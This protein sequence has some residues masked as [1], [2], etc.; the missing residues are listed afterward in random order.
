MLTSRNTKDA[1]TQG[2]WSRQF[3]KYSSRNETSNNI[4]ITFL[5]FYRNSLFILE[6]VGAPLNRFG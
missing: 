4:N 2:Q 1:K 5:H 6:T 3:I